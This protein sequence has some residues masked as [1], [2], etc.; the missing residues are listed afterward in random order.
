[1]IGGDSQS[2]FD[3]TCRDLIL[4]EYISFLC[5]FIRIVIDNKKHKVN[6]I[7]FMM[8]VTFFAKVINYLYLRTKLDI[9]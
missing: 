4:S 9:K 6:I 8:G 3:T 1:M 2:S 7:F 5:A